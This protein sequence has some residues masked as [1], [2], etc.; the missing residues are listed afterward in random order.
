MIGNQKM[1]KKI[2]LA[3]GVVAM[4]VGLMNTFSLQ[5]QVNTTTGGVLVAL[6]GNCHDAQGH[7]YAYNTVCNT[8]FSKCVATK[9]PPPPIP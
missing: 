1:L 7:V 9:C 3:T 6:I 4:S 5:A 8:G 2:T